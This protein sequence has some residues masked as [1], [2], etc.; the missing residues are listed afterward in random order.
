M[1]PQGHLL[2][3]SHYYLGLRGCSLNRWACFFPFLADRRSC[4]LIQVNLHTPGCDTA[5]V[6]MADGPFR[7]EG[8]RKF[9]PLKM[10]D[11][12]V[13]RSHRSHS[14]SSSAPVTQLSHDTGYA[15]CCVHV[16]CGLSWS[17]KFDCPK[18]QGMLPSIYKI[19]R[20]MESLEKPLS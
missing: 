2:C 3:I 20:N 12:G 11:V 1:L 16:A 17:R 10:G 14:P 15:V 6:C 9:T 7:P 8:I 5:V 19:S 18:T 4:R 13:P